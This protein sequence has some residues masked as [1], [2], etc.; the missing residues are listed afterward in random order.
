MLYSSIRQ[1]LDVLLSTAD[2]PSTGLIKGAESDATALPDGSKV[3]KPAE[4]SVSEEPNF[5]KE[6][7]EYIKNTDPKDLELE[8]LWRG[9]GNIIDNPVY[10]GSETTIPKE[11]TPASAAQQS[12][13][14]A[15]RQ[16]SRKALANMQ[17][18]YANKAHSEAME[19]VRIARELR[20]ARKAG[21]TDTVQQ[22][23][24]RREAIKNTHRQT[25]DYH[26]NIK[27]YMQQKD[28]ELYNLLT[29]RHAGPPADP[30][31]MQTIRDAHMTYDSLLSEATRRNKDNRSIEYSGTY[32]GPNKRQESGNVGTAL[33]AYGLYGKG[34]NDVTNNIPT[35]IGHGKSYANQQEVERAY[36]LPLSK[37]GITADE[38]LDFMRPEPLDGAN[39]KVRVFGVEAVKPTQGMRPPKYFMV[40]SEQLDQMR[41]SS[42]IQAAVRNTDIRQQVDSQLARLFGPKFTTYNIWSNNPSL[43]D[44]QSD[45]RAWAEQRPVGKSPEPTGAYVLAAPPSKTPITN[46]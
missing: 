30:A 15:A 18:M 35:S 19:L 41:R 20:A 46:R 2:T 33:H 27:S 32:T 37:Y 25:V 23:L 8:E 39:N 6:T 10:T 40:N 1:R 14:S 24:Y 5:A 29:M 45:P 11:T 26:Q 44:S 12:S 43:L 16:P 38:W 22:L 42:I 7:E 3:E 13:P 31:V 17:A 34:P 28:P 36:A 9:G 21:D 4:K